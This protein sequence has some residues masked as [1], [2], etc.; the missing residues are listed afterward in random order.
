MQAHIEL[1]TRRR[2]LTGLELVDVPST[3]LAPF[4][5]SCE[6][7]VPPSEAPG[8]Q[9]GSLV[10]GAGVPARTLQAMPHA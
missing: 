6:E 1:G 3:P 4:G 8:D 5:A 9:A 7:V 2:A 10:G